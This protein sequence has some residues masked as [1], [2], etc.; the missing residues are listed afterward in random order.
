MEC[1]VCILHGFPI[2]GGAELDNWQV[3]RGEDEI[4]HLD[5]SSENKRLSVEMMRAYIQIHGLT[6]GNYPGDEHLGE[7]DNCLGDK[8][9]KLEFRLEI[10]P[11]YAEVICP[12]KERLSLE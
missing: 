11:L 2:W 9:F 3:Q 6:K 8:V 4:S 1:D 12:G 10:F 5:L 7:R